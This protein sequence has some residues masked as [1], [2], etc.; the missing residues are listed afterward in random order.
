MMTKPIVMLVLA[1]AVV[2]AALLALMR[3]LGGLSDAQLYDT[4]LKAGL[5]LLIILVV[6]VA[7][8]AL[9]KPKSDK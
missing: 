4:G 1:L 5:V 8:S 2:I 6:G 9:S 3:V 7:V